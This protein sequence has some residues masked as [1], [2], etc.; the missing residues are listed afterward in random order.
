LT[1]PFF[2]FLEA[3]QPLASLTTQPREQ[4]RFSAAPAL[5]DAKKTAVAPETHTRHHGR[6]NV[7]GKNGTA[8]VCQ[9]GSPD[10]PLRQT[11]LTASSY[12]QQRIS[13]IG[14]NPLQCA[15]PPKDVVNRTVTVSIRQRPAQPNFTLD[16]GFP[17]PN[18]EGRAK[19]SRSCHPKV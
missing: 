3:A 9:G 6:P 12:W 13:A 8:D 4:T 14:I 16:S 18:P 17:D 7:T 1:R 2:V 19:R 5:A 10:K 11:R 15:G